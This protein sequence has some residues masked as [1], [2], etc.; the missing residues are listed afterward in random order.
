MADDSWRLTYTQ[1]DYPTLDAES[2]RY[3][4]AIFPEINN[5]R[6]GTPGRSFIRL[7]TG[8][9]DMLGYSVD[10]AAMESR[11]GS[12]QQV[13]NAALCAEG[14]AYFP[15]G[16][17]PA[18]T[19]ITFTVV[20]GAVAP[21]GGI[22][23][24]AGTVVSRSAPSPALDF[25]TLVD[26]EILE[27][28]SSVTVP[29][30]EGTKVT[31]EVLVASFSRTNDAPLYTLANRRVWQDSL[32]VHVGTE[33][34]TGVPM[35]ELSR[36]PNY[37]SFR[38]LNDLLSLQCFVW[39]PF[40]GPW[41]GRVISNGMLVTADYIRHNGSAGVTPPG[42]I[43]RIQGALSSVVTA[44]NAN[45]TSGGTDGEDADTIRA[46]APKFYS[47]ANVAL[48]EEQIVGVAQSVGGVDKV[49]VSSVQ[50]FYI[51][52]HVLPTGGGTASQA[53]LDA[54]KLVVTARTIIGAEV[55]VL[56]ILPAYVVFTL[57]VYAANRLLSRDTIRQRVRNAI[58]AALDPSKV[59][60]GKGFAM[61]DV[62]VLVEGV[63]TTNLDHVDIKRLS[64]VP[65]TVPSVAGLPAMS[66]VL[67]NPLTDYASYVITAQN[68]TQ[69][70]VSKNGVIQAVTGTIGTP[71][72][73]DG[74][75]IT[76]TVG[77][78]GELF[79]TP[80]G[81]TYSFTTSAYANNVIIDPDE[82]MALRQAGDLQL[83]VY[84]PGEAAP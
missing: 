61:S 44:T 47:G 71:Y 38:V 43:T 36:G 81:Q 69:F 21:V 35:S 67:I 56:P 54:V 33:V 8:L 59:T 53:M 78:P 46:K 32:Q 41:A 9:V 26:G 40:T 57:N 48:S 29:A 74:G 50:G 22:A 73:T 13:Q 58:V 66:E 10:Q 30:A 64:R 12:A 27:G 11:L 15:D 45:A 1:R 65:R 49:T 77:V 68:A 17:V 39:F 34:W 31:G 5:L 52:L 72:T 70:D 2:E 83:N 76:F 18:Q 4:Q 60:P 23:I 55:V 62:A 75:E 28:K 63:D 25:L 20:G 24:P 3:I 14:L 79:V 16:P 6:Q 82:F 42:K 80:F 19:D 84:Y 7:L 37:P 51:T